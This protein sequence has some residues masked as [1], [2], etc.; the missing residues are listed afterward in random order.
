MLPRKEVDDLV[1]KAQ[2]ELARKKYKKALQI[3]DRIEMISPDH[4]QLQ[5]FRDQAYFGSGSLLLQ[6][7]NYYG[8]L[9]QLKKVSNEYKG[10]DEA[11]GKA[12]RYIQ[13]QASEEKM[14]VAEELLGKGDYDGAINVCEE[15]LSQDIPLKAKQAVKD[16]YYTAHYR[17]AKQLME[18][19][20]DKKALDSLDVL[21]KD[22]KDSAQLR[23]QARAKLNAVAENLYRRGVK[24]FLNEELEQAISSW[25]KAL[26]I[27]P[28]HPKAQQDIDNALKL[29]DKWRGLEDGDKKSH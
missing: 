27:N 16:I 10:R 14:R 7:K 25:K 9:E 4:D 2:L 13:K 15:I 21:D 12:R 11:I 19:G 22:Y 29:L 28:N 6:K 5:T 1:K 18:Q 26:S 3:V 24:F 23:T 8:A 17:L 20:E